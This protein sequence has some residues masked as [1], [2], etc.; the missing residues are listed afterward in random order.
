MK[1]E[2][3]GERNVNRLARLMTM[4][5]STA[6]VNLLDRI[7]ASHARHIAVMPHLMLKR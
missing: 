1:L 4:S 5:D 3:D 7:A 6:E 2:S